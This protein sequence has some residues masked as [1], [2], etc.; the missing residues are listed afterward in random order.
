MPPASDDQPSA[1]LSRAQRRAVEELLRISPVVDELGARFVRAGHELYLVGGSVR[2]SLLGRLGDDLD[3]TTDAHPDAIEA[4]VAGWAH[5]TWTTGKRFGTIG[6]QRGDY[7]IEITTYRTESYDT[8]SRKPDVRFGTSLTDDLLRRDFT[9]NAMAVAIP[10][11]RFVDPFRGLTDLATRTLRT[12][13]APE[14]SF[15]DDPLRMLRAARFAAQLG[16][17]VAD[18]VVAAMRAMAERLRIVSAER[19][20]VELNKL[21]LSP[22]PRTGLTLL[23]DTGIADV[24]L[25]ELPALRLSI[26]PVH[27]HKDVY[28]HTLAVL[29]RAMSLETGEPDLTLRMAALLHDIGKPKTRRFEDGGGVSF[30][31]HEVVGRD[32][33]RNRLAAL[34]YPKNFIDDVAMLVELHLRFHGYSDAAWTDA[35]VRRYVRDAGH[36]LD[37]L[38][39]LV[40]SDC[41]T[42][43]RRKADMLAHAY[44]DLERRIAELAQQEELDSIRPDLDGSAIMRVLAIPPG[45]LVGQARNH[46]LELRI[47]RGPLPHED[48]LR[49]LLEWAAG[50]GIEP[51]SYDEALRR[52]DA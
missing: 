52:L 17:T 16:F 19:I 46:L 8:D 45:R 21:L 42:R 15:G 43:N 25:P 26:D 27:R 48:A 38:H 29:E 49:E 3:F 24:V 35:G 14:D 6:A 23:V 22:D 31:H 1:E 40:R 10:E 33:A 5:A 51:P 36:L 39:L 47:E 7:R 50:Q 37:R 32:L 30:H 11:R 34:K 28:D 18:D 44:D 41:T 2:D 13:G 9:V 12:P 20:A 4:L